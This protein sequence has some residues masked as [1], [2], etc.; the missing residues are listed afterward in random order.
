[1]FVFNSQYNNWI[2][3]HLWGQKNANFMMLHTNV[4][5]ILIAISLQLLLKYNITMNTLP[6]Y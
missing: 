3:P 4:N 5:N 1:M 6:L 2:Y